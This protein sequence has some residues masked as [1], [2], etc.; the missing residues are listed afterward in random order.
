MEA[1]GAHVQYA[2][3][4][5]A[6]NERLFLLAPSLQSTLLGL[7]A[8]CLDVTKLELIRFSPR[9]TYSLRDFELEQQKTRTQVTQ[10][11]ADF[12]QNP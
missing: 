10:Q 11:L 1:V 2:E 5:K 8:L 3:R 4:Q 9:Q 7:R 6:L 12:R